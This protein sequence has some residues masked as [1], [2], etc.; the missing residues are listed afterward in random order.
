MIALSVLAECADPRTAIGPVL[1]SLKTLTP[2]R[3]KARFRVV[4]GSVPVNEPL[5]GWHVHDVLRETPAAPSEADP[6]AETG[7]R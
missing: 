7:A 5:E 4:H 3:G 2:V 6:D 1:E